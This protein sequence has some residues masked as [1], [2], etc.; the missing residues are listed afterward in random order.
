MISNFLNNNNN[1]YFLDEEIEIFNLI[2][3]NNTSSDI[4]ESPGSDTNDTEPGDSVISLLVLFILIKLKISISS[5][6][7]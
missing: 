7:K 5:S 3:I 1:Y 6:K 4:T 2:N